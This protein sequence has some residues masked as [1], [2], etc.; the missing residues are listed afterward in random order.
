[1][2]S[3]YGPCLIMV[4][5]YIQM[6]RAAKRLRIKDR[7]TT[8]WSIT[9]RDENNQNGSLNTEDIDEMT[10]LNCTSTSLSN[11]SSPK[12]QHHHRPSAFL[13]A[14]RIP[15]VEIGILS[16]IGNK[17][18]LQ[19]HSRSTEKGEDKARKTLG[20]IMSVFII[21]WLPFFIIA[22]LKSQRLVEA[23]PKWLDVIALWLGY[24]NR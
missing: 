21:C 22:L 8:K 23:L 11:N 19:M 9:I 10:N 13:S 3:F 12:R 5:L 1:M 7:L 2:I 20:V 4:I 14:V 15:L 17:A 18:R 6:W 24:S 16:I